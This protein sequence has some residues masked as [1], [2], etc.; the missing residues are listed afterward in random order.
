MHFHG[1]FPDEQAL[2]PF[3]DIRTSFPSSSANTG[4]DEQD[5][6]NSRVRPVIFLGCPGWSLGNCSE[7]PNTVIPTTPYMRR[8]A[9]F[10]IL[11]GLLGV[12]LSWSS[13]WCIEIVQNAFETGLLLGWFT[14]TGFLLTG[15]GIVYICWYEL[16]GYLSVRSVDRLATSL[17]SDD[18]RQAKRQTIRWLHAVK[19]ECRVEA[20]QHASTTEEIR[21]MLIP[22]INT[23]DSKVDVLIAKESV[24]TGVVVGISPW[25]V[26]DG[27][28]VAW[29]QLRLMRSIAVV[30][31]MRPS[32][33][34]TLRLLR[35]VLVSVAFADASEHLTQ[36]IAT[37]VPSLGGLLPA[38]GQAV[39]IAVLTARLGRSCKVAC[40]PLQKT[41]AQPTSMFAKIKRVIHRVTNKTAAKEKSTRCSFNASQSLE[42]P[43]SE[44][45][46]TNEVW[47][48]ISRRGSMK[49][50]I[51][52]CHTPTCVKQF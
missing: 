35:R 10:T 7:T 23:L 6:R 48:P 15:S 41:V 39:A 21:N 12:L 42:T 46:L 33:F 28:V 40:R 50:G 19:Q 49:T 4:S 14:L 52:P 8:Y 45:L 34:G 3:S 31:G 30:Y 25:A 47:S 13:L 9:F 24:L 18:V 16:R 32:T 1:H 20:V 5:I 29:R 38:A 44:I 22:Y 2:F 27:L 36:W 51:N 11:I 17:Q 26:V 37:K 43:N